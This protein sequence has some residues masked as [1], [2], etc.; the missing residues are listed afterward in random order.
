MHDVAGPSSMG[1]LFALFPSLSWLSWLAGAGPSRSTR[2]IPFAVSVYADAV[3]E[4]RLRTFS[5]VSDA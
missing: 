2:L 4:S 3:K 1:H 5:P